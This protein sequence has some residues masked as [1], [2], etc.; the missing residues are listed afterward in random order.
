METGEL[1]EITLT[2]PLTVLLNIQ[3]ILKF[4]APG[5]QKSAFKINN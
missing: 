3:S 1:L 5:R 4:S 2:D